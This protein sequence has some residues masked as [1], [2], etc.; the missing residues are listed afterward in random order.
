MSNLVRGKKYR[1]W[2]RSGSTVTSSVREIV[3]EFLGEGVV[4]GALPCWQF[5]LAS[6]RI[7]SVERD[8]VEDCKEV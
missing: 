6:G 2:W 8:L 3:G 4:Y 5:R 1:V 7:Q